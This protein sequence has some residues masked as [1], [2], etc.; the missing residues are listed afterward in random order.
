MTSPVVNGAGSSVLTAITR[1]WSTAKSRSTMAIAPA[2]RRD[3]SCGV[4][5][6]PDLVQQS[7]DPFLTLPLTDRGRERSSAS[8]LVRA[9]GHKLETRGHG[10]SARSS[11]NGL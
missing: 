8:K 2:Q 4:A 3:C 9:N 10:L 11:E 6:P 5:A 7:Q 1:S